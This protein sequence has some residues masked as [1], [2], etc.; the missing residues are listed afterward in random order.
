MLNAALP[1]GKASRAFPTDHV[2]RRD[3]QGVH[4]EGLGY[5]ETLFPIKNYSD[6]FRL[7][8]SSALDKTGS[9]VSNCP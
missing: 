8:K 1:P 7:P 4:W 5:S 9:T 6:S 2:G 3:S